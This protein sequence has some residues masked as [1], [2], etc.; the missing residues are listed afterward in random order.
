MNADSSSW[1]S[2][3]QLL[4]EQARRFGNRTLFRFEGTDMT[5]AQAEEQTNRL[6]YVLMAHGV[7]KGAHVAVMLPNG[8]DFPLAWLAIAKVG[9]VMVPI[10]TQYQEKDLSYILSNSEAQC[11][12]ISPAYMA[13][14]QQGSCLCTLRIIPPDSLVDCQKV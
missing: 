1:Q 3:G 13:L 11:A 7:G 2:L 12:L 4:H 10:N 6:A 14:L 8:F 5:F 9:A